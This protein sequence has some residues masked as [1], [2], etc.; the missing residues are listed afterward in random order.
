MSTLIKIFIL[1]LGISFSALS[2]AQQNIAVI[3]F[4]TAVSKS[5]YAKQ[6]REKL[7]SSESYQKKRARYNELGKEL[8][9]MEKE[10]KTNGLTW[11]DEQKQNHNQRA[12]DKVSEI[13]KV[14]GQLEAEV[15]RVNKTMAQE[16]NPKIDKILKELMAEK[17]IGLLLK[18]GTVHFATEDFDIT[19][20]LLDRLNKTN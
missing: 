11:S 20:E 16:L 10:A 8:K 19:Q 13:N 18:A 4:E 14:G 1:T 17:K 9:A 3:D 5:N 2:I 7:E 6:A 12:K 15:G